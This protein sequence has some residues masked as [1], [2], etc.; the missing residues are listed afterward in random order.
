M[1]TKLTT[2]NDGSSV[3]KTEQSIYL[4]VIEMEKHNEGA[5]SNIEFPFTIGEAFTVGT[6][7]LV[8][9]FKRPNNYVTNTGIRIT[10]NWTKSQDTD[11]SGNKVKWKL[12]YY[13][14]D[15]GGDVAEPT[16][17][18]VLYSERTYEDSGTATHI[19]YDTG[20]DFVIAAENVPADKKY[21]Y[22]KFEAVTP[23][24]NTLVEP[25][26]LTVNIFYTGYKAIT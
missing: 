15:I 21:L 14:I 10:L 12:S 24:S 23:S 2:I 13:F 18:G 20:N 11:Q 8:A 5:P 22:L 4:P 25:V 9:K 19:A 3:I 7:L 16:P 1:V 6:D 26:L 17:D